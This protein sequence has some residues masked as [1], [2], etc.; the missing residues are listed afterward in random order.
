M[1]TVFGLSELRS[2]LDVWRSNWK[3]TAPDR[4]DSREPDGVQPADRDTNDNA[5]YDLSLLIQNIVI[6]K[7]VADRN[8]PTE[9]QGDPK[10]LDGKSVAV[11]KSISKDDVE[12]FTLLS[13]Q[14]EA[15]A[16]MEFVDNCIAKGSSLDSI[17]IDLLA[18][19]ARRLGDYWESDQSNFVDVTMGLWRIQ[20]VLREL[21]LRIPPPAIAGFGQRSALFS[22]M[23]GEQHS[24]GTLMI[25]ECFYRAGWDSDILIEPT[26]S[27][28]IGKFAN[29][30]YDLIGLTVSCDYPR[31]VL[32]G[33]VSAIKSVS[34]NPDTRIMLGGRLINDNPDLIETCGADATAAD[35]PSAVKLAD[36][37]VSLKAD[38][39]ESLV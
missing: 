18:P 7:L 15:R 23:P 21:T 4:S 32:I 28:L 31:G 34:N 13:V 24:F 37:L 29:C 17:Y 14:S 1:A 26:R 20:E 22:T 38:I 3:I 25:A 6:P 33:L 12:K 39:F 27:E 10:F 9:H 16:L 8:A 30:H 36:K 5:A 35:A 2:K 11:P 19:A